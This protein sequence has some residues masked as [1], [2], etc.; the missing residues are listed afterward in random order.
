MNRD[1]ARFF[2]S[3]LTV[4]L[5]IGT[6]MPGSWKDAAI[7]P[8]ASPV[9]LAALAHVLLFAGICF[10]IPA[11]RFWRVRSWHVFAFGLALALSTE[12]L[13]FFAIDRHPNLA[14]VIQDMAGAFMGWALGQ[15]HRLR[16][17]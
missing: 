6:L 8:L 15:L 3:F 7:K 9:D 11:A 14:G 17:S 13:Q 10:T 1:A 2:S 16:R 12:G 4:A 5:F